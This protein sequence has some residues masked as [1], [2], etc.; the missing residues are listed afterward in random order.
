[1]NKRKGISL[2]ELLAVIVI[3]GII[4]AIAVPTVGSLIKKTKEKACQASMSSSVISYNT[5]VQFEN[6]TTNDQRYAA[7]EEVMQYM[8]VTK[9]N[10]N[11][12]L[13]YKGLCSDK[14]GVYTYLFNEF[15]ELSVTCSYHQDNK[16]EITREN[17]MNTLMNADTFSEYL[18]IAY[19]RGELFS[20]EGVIMNGKNWKLSKELNEMLANQFGYTE[21]NFS[22]QFQINR[23]A[24]IVLNETLLG[25]ENE[26]AA[27][28]STGYYV[29][30]FTFT[31]TNI[32]SLNPGD[33]VPNCSIKRVIIDS[34]GNIVHEITDY[35][36]IECTIKQKN[37]GNHGAYNVLGVTASAGGNYKWKDVLKSEIVKS[38][39]QA[40]K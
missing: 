18:D 1:M 12:G 29:L 5:H 23:D 4:A 34:S 25:K 40:Q 26:K 27:T 35:Q 11:V 10:S 28:G 9:E 7:L 32:N 13:A 33:K 14:D 38:G 6:I 24:Q 19:K 17:I 36:D 16:L 37:D 21:A 39:I 15:G 22:W 20:E 3:L 30:D 31:P 2:V 8:N